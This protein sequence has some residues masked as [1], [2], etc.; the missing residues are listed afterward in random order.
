MNHADK[1]FAVKH[2]RM[3]I[4]IPIIFHGPHFSNMYF[5]SKIVIDY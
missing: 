1:R 3:N 2:S 4:N 5:N